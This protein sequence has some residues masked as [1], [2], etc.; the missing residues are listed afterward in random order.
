A[1]LQN[2]RRILVRYDRYSDNFLSFVHLG[3]MRIM[4]QRY[5]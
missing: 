5:F 3:C 2:Y 4:L 1:W